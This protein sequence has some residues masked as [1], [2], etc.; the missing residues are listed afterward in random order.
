MNQI[1]SLN[2]KDYSI[3]QLP[4]AARVQVA[5]IQVADAELA[6]L[7]QQQ[8]LVQTAR[9]AYV[10][11]LVAVLDVPE[12]VLA[13]TANE[14]KPAPVKKTTARKSAKKTS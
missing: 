5:N 8:A 7:G 12:A 13:A 2:G 10:S 11:A 3:D 6:R 14:D 1:I 4:V 9:N